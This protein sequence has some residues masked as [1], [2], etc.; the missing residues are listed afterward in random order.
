MKYKVPNIARR[1]VRLCSTKRE[2]VT[3]TQEINE[4]LMQNSIGVI[5]VP[6]D[7][8]RKM[9]VTVKDCRFFEN[10]PQCVEVMRVNI[11]A[12][13]RLIQLNQSRDVMKK[14]GIALLSEHKVVDRFSAAA[15]TILRKI[16]GVEQVFNL[17]AQYVEK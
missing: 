2:P 5:R 16:S 1:I 12:L 6:L 11:L 10:G 8:T 9:S 4:P 17:V 3:E 7:T 15:E 14:R 13:R